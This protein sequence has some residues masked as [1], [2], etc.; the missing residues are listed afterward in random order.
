M[1]VPLS[2]TRDKGHEMDYLRSVILYWLLAIIQAPYAFPRR[3][4]GTRMAF[5]GRVAEQASDT[6]IKQGVVKLL[7]V[8]VFD[9]FGAQ[10][11]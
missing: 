11:H 6:G 1:T 9:I 10:C 8:Y 7:V 5:E 2:A 3:S 4:V